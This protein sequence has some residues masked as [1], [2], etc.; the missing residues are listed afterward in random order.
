MKPKAGAG[1]LKRG[2]GRQS[3]GEES[4]RL[5]EKTWPD[6]AGIITYH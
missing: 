1:V 6:A 4:I 2:W 5:R 3:E